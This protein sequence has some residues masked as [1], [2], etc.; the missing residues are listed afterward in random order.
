MRSTDPTKSHVGMMTCFF[1]G[2]SKGILLHKRLR[3]VLPREACYDHEPCDKC[4]GYM[5]QGVII[6]ST[7]DGEEGSDN[8]YRTGGWWVVTEEG[9]RGFTGPGE[10]LDSIL[11]KRFA[12]MPDSVCDQIGLPREAVNNG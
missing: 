8:P 12:F 9:V 5:E 1:C 3:Q 10:L 7:K 4:R 6:V 11:E 2:E